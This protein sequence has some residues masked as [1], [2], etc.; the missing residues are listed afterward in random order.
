MNGD[1][2][3]KH[4]LVELRDLRKKLDAHMTNN[5]EEHSA[6]KDKVSAG[7]IEFANHKG[8]VTI[9]AAGIASFVSV[10]FAAILSWLGMHR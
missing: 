10:L 5:T 8:K 9:M 7:H 6:I 4:I 3:K 2:L 1:E